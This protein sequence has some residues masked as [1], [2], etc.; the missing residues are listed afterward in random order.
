MRVRFPGTRPQFSPHFKLRLDP[1]ENEVPEDLAERMIASGLVE[2][3]AL[4]ADLEP[5]PD[6]TAGGEHEGA[7]PDIAPAASKKR[8]KRGDR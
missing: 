2:R 4:V 8:K 3:V 6:A 7:S 1:G 5:E